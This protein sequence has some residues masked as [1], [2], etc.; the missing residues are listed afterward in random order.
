MPMP[1]E[2][3]N[4]SLMNKW[5]SVGQILVEVSYKKCRTSCLP[6]NTC[7]FYG[8]LLCST[9]YEPIPNFKF[10]MFNVRISNLIFE[11]CRSFFSFFRS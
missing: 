3:A 8:Y 1:T 6:N 2:L 9:S 5:E 7:S 11:L 4:L 10:Q